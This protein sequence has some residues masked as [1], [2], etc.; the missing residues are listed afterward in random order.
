MAAAYTQSLIGKTN[1]SP[2]GQAVFLSQTMINAA[3]ANMWSLAGDSS[4]LK[5][6]KRRIRGCGT[7]DVKLKEPVVQ[8]QATTVDPQLY[9]LLSFKS[10]TLELYTSDDNDVEDGDE[11]DGEDDATKTWDTKDWVFGFSV[12]ISTYPIPPPPS[13]TLSRKLTAFFL[14]ARKMVDKSSPAFKN[15]VTQAGLSEGAFSLAQLYLDS[16]CTLSPVFSDLFIH[17]PPTVVKK[18]TER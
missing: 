2:Y 5:T 3:L 1:P 8:L 7:I 10:G 6:F 15:A 13:S 18:L 12:K 9:L 4:P 11:G 16:T 14:V 17:W